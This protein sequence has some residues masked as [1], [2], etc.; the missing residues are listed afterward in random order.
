MRFA[1]SGFA[2]LL[3]AALLAIVF[4]VVSGCSSDDPSAAPVTS[5]SDAAIPDPV[6]AGAMVD[7]SVAATP[8]PRSAKGADR[9][10]SVVISHPFD[11]TGAKANA[12]EVLRLA[13]DG[14]LSRSGTTF[15]MGNNFDSPI[16]F[17]PDGEI[18]VS[19]HD[20]DGTLG[21]FRI[22]DAGAVTVLEPAFGLNQFYADAAVFSADGSRLF[23]IDGN[24]N[25]SGGVHEIAIG[26][27]GKPTYKGRIAVAAAPSAIAFVPGTSRAA[28]MA[29]GADGV[30]AG[31]NL[32]LLDL[33]GPGTVAGSLA[34]FGD[35]DISSHGIAFTPDGKLGF[36]ADGNEV[37]GTNRVG[38]FAVDGTSFTKLSQFEVEGPSGVVTSPYGNAAL[39]TAAGGGAIDAFYTFDISGAGAA[40]TVTAKGKFSAL[41]GAKPQ[42]PVCPLVIAEGP[43]KG[44]ILVGEVE[45]VRRLRFE[46]NGNV[47]DLGVF[48][49]P[50]DLD[51]VVGGV[52]VQ[53]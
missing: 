11:A 49:I 19:V 48:P 43:Q 12:Y 37:L 18:G 7:G 16:V 36:V 38:T 17:S 6:E 23:V 50:G 22:D 40:A 28:V 46:A 26:C 1:P 13:K 24:L 52:G 34:L 32:F 45:G 33:A 8:C 21:V 20:K 39:V 4:A 51:M 53:P 3:P 10:R 5:G 9:V 27:D 44:L 29:I 15:Q 30:P 42:L 14:S 47:T 41:T 35:K 25:T 31:H 2:V